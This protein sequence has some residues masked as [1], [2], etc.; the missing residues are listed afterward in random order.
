MFLKQ[1]DGVE[2]LKGVNGLEDKEKAENVKSIYLL[3]VLHTV[4]ESNYQTLFYINRF[5]AVENG[6]LIRQQMAIRAQLKSVI[7]VNSIFL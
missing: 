2:P 5:L 4:C 6:L 3:L 7:N 1:N